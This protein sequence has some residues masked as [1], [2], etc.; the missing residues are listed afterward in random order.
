MSERVSEKE[1]EEKESERG[2]R[3]RD[4]QYPHSVHKILNIYRL[5]VRIFEEQ[6]APTS[7]IQRLSPKLTGPALPHFS[8]Y[9]GMEGGA[10]WGG[11]GGYALCIQTCS[12]P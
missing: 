1:R 6:Y 9:G 11:G 4:S 3:E 5:S 2:G 12:G 8:V 7:N 10:G